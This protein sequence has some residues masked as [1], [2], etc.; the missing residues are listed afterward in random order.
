MDIK[1]DDKMTNESGIYDLMYAGEDREEIEKTI[2]TAWPGAII[3]NASD[4]IHEGRFSV[5]MDIDWDAWIIWVMENGLLEISLHTGLLQLE[6]HDKY[7]ELLLQAA[8]NRGYIPD[9]KDKNNES[10]DGENVE[11]IELEDGAVMH[12]I[13]DGEA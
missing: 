3:E 1:K 13:K 7:M 6:N 12:I 8:I 10:T 11:E 4:F 9:D 5:E 2:R